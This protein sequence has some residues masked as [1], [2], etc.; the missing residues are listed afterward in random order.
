M[1]LN[2]L[3]FGKAMSAALFVLLLSV[4]GMKNALAQNQVATMQH[5]DTITGVTANR[6]IE[7]CFTLAIYPDE[8][9]IVCVKPYGCGTADGSSWENAIGNL[10]LAL[11][12]FNL[13]QTKP[14]IWVATGT[15]YGD[16][17]STNAFTMAEG[18]NVYGGFVGNEPADYDLSLRDFENNASILDGQNIQRVLYQ[19][20]SFSDTTT[21][22]GFT[23]MNGYTESG[24]GG[25]D[26]VKASVLSNCVVM[27]N[28][29]AE[30]GGINAFGSLIR[31]CIVCYNRGTANYIARG[32]IYG[33]RS[34]IVN[35]KVYNNLVDGNNYYS[36]GGIDANGCYIDRCEVFNNVAYVG[37]VELSSLHYISPVDTIISSSIQNSL[38]CNNQG[39][40]YRSG[41][42]LLNAN[43]GGNISVINCDVVNNYGNGIYITIGDSD[44][45]AL[46]RNSIVWG[47]GIEGGVLD[48]I[49]GGNVDG[50]RVEHCAV[51]G[52]YDGLGNLYLN[53]S[54]V[55]L[56][57]A[58]RFENPTETFG[59]VESMEGYSWLLQEGSPCINKG[60]TMGI[61][62]S[63]YDLAGNQRVQQGRIDIGCYESPFQETQDTS[64]GD[65][66]VYVKQ[67]GEGTMDGTSW[68]NAMPNINVAIETANALDSLVVWVAAG[69]YYGD[70]VADHNAFTMAEG[71]NVYGGFAGNEPADYDLNLR[72]FEANET[73][74]DGQN[75]QRV[76]NQ[77]T[78]FDEATVWD[79]F[80][81]K[82]G[83]NDYVSAVY[84]QR[85][86]IIRNCVIS[87]NQ[88][89]P[90][91]QYYSGNI[92]YAKNAFV[93]NCK[94]NNN[95]TNGWMKANIVESY[96]TVYE[97]SLIYN[98]TCGYSGVGFEANNCVFNNIDFLNNDLAYMVGGSDNSFKNCIIWGNGSNYDNFDGEEFIT[99][100]LG[101]E[102]YSQDNFF[103]HCAIESNNQIEGNN[104]VLLHENIGEGIYH[105]R[106]E[107]P[108]P[109]IGV[110]D[111]LD[112]Y[113]WQ[114]LEGS[115]CINQG[116]TT[117]LNCPQHD[118]AGNQRIQQGRIDIGCYE[119]PYNGIYI[120]SYN[121]IVYVTPTGSGNN[122]GSSWENATSSI[123][124][125]MDISSANGDIDIWVAAG[126]YYGDSI[127]ENS[128]LTLRDGISI[129][130]GFA[131]D[132]PSDYD[133]NS[134]DFETNA[135]ILDGQN[136]QRV[137]LQEDYFENQTIVDGFVVRNG[138]VNGNGNHGG[139]AYLNYNTILKNIVFEHN[140]Q[141]ALCLSGGSNT[142]DKCIF[143]NN[144]G[145][146]IY[147]NISNE[148]TVINC[149][150][151]NNEGFGIYHVLS[152]HLN[153]INCTVVNNSS[154]GIYRDGS[155]WYDNYNITHI[156]NCI[157]W[158][159][160]EY[161]EQLYHI[162]DVNYSAVQDGYDGEGNITLCA[163]NEGSTLFYP[164]FQNPSPTRGVIDSVEIYSWTLM[165]NSVCINHGDTTG[166]LVDSFDLA[167]NERIQHGRIDIGC[168][169]SPSQGVEI[170]SYDDGIVYVTP[171]GAGTR[172]GN[173]WGNAMSSIS[174]AMETSKAMDS[175]VVWVA[176]GVYYGDS[177][178]EHNAFEVHG[179]SLYGGFVGNEPY[180]YDL[181]L[182]DF[183]TNASILDGQYVQ[184]VLYCGAYLEETLLDGFTIRNGFVNGNGA[185][186]YTDD[187]TV[188]KN[189]VIRDCHAT[190]NGG[191]IYLSGAY[192]DGIC[193]ILENSKVI[194]N[195]SDN[196][197]GGGAFVYYTSIL[198]SKIDGNMGSKGGGAYLYEGTIENCLVTDNTSYFD[199]GGVLLERGDVKN[200]SV[201]NNSVTNDGT[202]VA[203]GL[204]TDWTSS[205]CSVSN[206]IIWGNKTNGYIHN[207][208]DRHCF[209]YCAIEGM[210]VNGTG[211]I[212]LASDNDGLE[213]LNYVRFIDVENNDFRLQA[214]SVCVDA[215]DPDYLPY[216]TLD[217][218]GRPRIYNGRIDIGCYEFNGTVIETNLSDNI[219][220]GN[221]YL[222]N[223][224]EIIQPEVGESEYSIT[225]PSSQGTDSIV[226]L[227]L[228]VHPA[229]FF[230]EDTTLCNTTSFEWHGHTYT[231]SGIYYDTLQT[232]HGCDSVFQLSLE[233]FDTPLGEFASMTPT[234]NY[235]FTSLPIIFSWDAVSRAEYYNLYLWNVNDPEPDAPV[236]SNIYN[237]SFYIPSLQNHQ[238]YNWYVEAVNTCFSAS[239]SVRSFSLNIPPTM[240]VS[241]SS[242][243]FGE[244]ALNNSNTLNMYAGGN[245]LDDTLTLQ[246]IGEDAA[247]FSFAQG[248]N[249]NGL[250]GGSLSVTFSPS[251][252]QYSYNADLVI[253]SGTLTQTVH[254]SGTL[255]DMFVFSTY[256]EQDVFPMGSAVPIHGTV[257]DLD[258]NPMPSAEVEV[259]VNVMN[260]SRSLY[261]TTGADGHFTVDFTP[262]NSES[263]YYT[264]NSGRV[265]HNSTAVHDDFN[266]PGMN[267]VTNGWIL[268][269]VVQNETTTGSI[270][271]RNRSQIPLNNIQV[272]A[273]T[274]PEG[275]SFTFQPLSLQGM[276]EGVLEYS[277]TGSAL[278]SGNNYEEVRLVATSA[279]GATMNFSAWYYCA[280]P[281]GIL[282]AAPNNITTTMTKG[283]S[284]IVD[285]MLYNNGTGPT[286]NVY[287]DLPSVDWL[288][289]VGNDT[290]PSIAVH[291]S[292]YF[293]LRLSANENTPLVQYTGNIAVNCERGDGLS[294]PYTITAVSDSTGTLVVDVTD[295]YTY[296]GNGQH[297]AGATVTVKGYY[298]LQTVAIGL[299]GSDGIF[300]VEDIPEGYYR[301]SITAPQHAEYQA[302]IQIEGGQ[303][304]TQNIYL[305]YQAITYSWNVVPTE[306]EDEYTFELVVDY[307]TN[308]PVPVVVI[309]MPQTFP[310]L[311]EG[312]SYVFNYI[313]TNYGLVDTYDATLY[314]PIGHPL[315]DFTPL[316]TEIDTLHAQ[317]SVV[318][319]CTMTV[320]TG[321][322]SPLV[323]AALNG[324]GERDDDC[325]D[326]VKTEVQG[327][328]YCRGEKIP[329]TYYCW[330]Q[331][332][333]HPCSTPPSNGG[334]GSSGP[335]GGGGGGGGGHYS[336]SGGSST[337]PVTT[338]QQ[339]CNDDPTL[340]NAMDELNSCPPQ[341][342]NTPKLPPVQPGNNR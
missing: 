135:T 137:L 38:V 329:T 177:L 247:M 82:N 297:L 149:L 7:A 287:L 232:T 65:G 337:P 336:G 8:N 211:N 87:N 83:L 122:D 262:A 151:N 51:E 224:F 342:D 295:D 121:G 308:V 294:L 53:H 175:L 173:S 306:I 97:N 188:L 293:S 98:N 80:S 75:V 131:G 59:P 111:S 150:I 112:S 61:L 141:Y 218:A 210:L 79:G 84:L 240:N 302:T 181:S 201:I 69:T 214:N 202:D 101:E 263:G 195:V 20:N 126:V 207:T 254:L 145:G 42:V 129:F 330:R 264:I 171:D 157:I 139:G 272:T 321:Q 279:E 55:G 217:F 219:C 14:T 198:N 109:T 215:G 265:G 31:N 216:D 18:V 242:L 290:L 176:A 9:N 284:K 27:N 56:I 244:V 100:S 144:H 74:L 307:E 43:Q 4:A 248:S 245:A 231:E 33:K 319:P 304:N 134:R 46:I 298:S 26:I 115:V 17:I 316:I 90:T 241:Q 250:T 34:I 167:G 48:Q 213:A 278:T 120:P 234:N 95:V 92:L 148:V 71:V 289:V 277:V 299:T 285:V 225:L 257:M 230:A 261:A 209:S 331:V 172:S 66:I 222:L 340:P 182:R 153:I 123:T 19:Q 125:A 326:Y 233:L 199:A 243:N 196:G 58:P 200:C 183:E 12:Y 104:I 102:G 335:G 311:A 255:A 169:E 186:V 114:L 309:D 318:I 282:Y 116:D 103:D 253:S 301:M 325:P 1:K 300:T 228:T 156:L 140:G 16:S 170:P 22:D 276:E 271:I 11:D 315:Y 313:I 280:E 81:I 260:T 29:G 5:N 49:Y 203:G 328:Y 67:E 64:Y 274:L 40:S 291:D 85:N 24:G 45:S 192:T 191:G 223:G 269:D 89:T 259:K 208:I 239:S 73:V 6:D 204:N 252:V 220:Q 28:Q 127:A 323:Y 72:D 314:P 118:L 124:L 30:V 268:W 281:R 163:G 270:V 221:D 166:L 133:L 206:T 333:T 32:G 152:S 146:G 275:C 107:N 60:D 161:G 132:E 94:V 78:E 185:G 339:G 286:G 238:T 193:S 267:L 174:D 160:S 13:Q 143:R 21:F 227:T 76:L 338:Q 249:W 110:M 154:C 251:A 10:Q 168:Y 62:L 266:I 288:S 96:S 256:V 197:N 165:E 23:I 317:S 162:N 187:P 36:V 312:E 159:N 15:Y 52:G 273:N 246:I 283:N 158:G 237:R 212:N 77:P 47:N 25:V 2:T 39:D 50:L 229:Y 136:A 68:S 327:Y 142:I 155:S 63:E 44:Y 147:T 258:D 341:F 205:E 128:V 54:N 334:G 303:T 41:G 105:P 117:G 113:S 70:S 37:G 138:T 322:R 324:R 194:N 35:C 108:T 99:A 320:R 226:N 91:T 180:D 184:R 164:R 332:G 292:A 190:F 3:Q 106:F 57:R 130:G 296:N 305:Q 86:S 178:P 189:C 88:V 93:T 179:V 310:E 235:P 119:S 236:S